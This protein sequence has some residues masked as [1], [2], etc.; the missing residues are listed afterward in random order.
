VF[1]EGL[2][3]ELEEKP[4]TVIRYLFLTFMLFIK[5]TPIVNFHRFF[6]F[7]AHQKY[8]ILTLYPN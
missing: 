4:D 2:M 1:L 8:E 7:K 5:E 3:E 6:I